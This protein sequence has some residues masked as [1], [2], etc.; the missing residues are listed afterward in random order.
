MEAFLHKPSCYLLFIR[1][2]GVWNYGFSLLEESRGSPKIYMDFV[3]IKGLYVT[4]ILNKFTIY[5]LS[6]LKIQNCF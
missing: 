3:D 5:L 2:G 1:G 4:L 6:V